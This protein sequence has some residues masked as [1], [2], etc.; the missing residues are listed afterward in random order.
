MEQQT[1]DLKFSIESLRKKE[2]TRE[3]RQSGML[4][5]PNDD[6]DSIFVTVRHLSLG[7]IIKVI[8]ANKG[9]Q[10][11][12]PQREIEESMQESRKSDLQ[13]ISKL[14]ERKRDQIADHLIPAFRK[15]VLR[16]DHV[17]K[18]LIYAFVNDKDII[19]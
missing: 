15:I 5:E 7:K 4:P 9:M 6:E 19:D 18:D 16:I 10:W 1:R 13:S 17:Y 14:I 8:K 11:C 3:L 2:E 12:C